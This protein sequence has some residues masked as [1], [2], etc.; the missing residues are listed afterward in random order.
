M[1]KITIWVVV[2]CSWIVLGKQ[3]LSGEL[4]PVPVSQ[5]PRHHLVFENQYTRVLNVVIPPGDITLFHKHSNDVVGVTLVGSLS[6][7]TEVMGGVRTD[8]PPDKDDEVWFEEFEKSPVIHR[9][10]NTGNR[11]IHYIVAE[12]LTPSPTAERLSPALKE[13]PG[14]KTELENRR[15]RVSRIFLDPG[16]STIEHKHESGY[17]VI[18][19]SNGRLTST[20]AG[21]QS[22]IETSPGFLYWGEHDTD[23]SLKNSGDTRLEIVEFEF[24]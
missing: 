23:H 22:T 2:F 8:D 4:S 24:R 1:S 3:G 15:I 6:G 17:V 20:C 19:E 7:W 18:A 14:Y 16:Q 21:I 9:V 11:Q 13:F 10:A 5:E 12:I